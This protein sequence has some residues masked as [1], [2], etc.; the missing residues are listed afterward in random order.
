MKKSIDYLLIF[1][2]IIESLQCTT[3]SFIFN[4]SR[5]SIIHTIKQ[6]ISFH[7]PN[8]SESAR[9]I[10]YPI[11]RGLNSLGILERRGTVDRPIQNIII[12]I[13][14]YTW[15]L[16]GRCGCCWLLLLHH[17]HHAPKQFFLEFTCWKLSFHDSLGGWARS[18]WDW[19]VLLPEGIL[20]PQ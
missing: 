11:V 18:C 12:V 7:L 17:G 5:M 16:S 15:S 3:L 19:Q 8:L 13:I 2:I 20:A 6:I 9:S 1:N 4:L 10:E 14:D